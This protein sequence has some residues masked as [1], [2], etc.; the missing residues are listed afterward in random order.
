M[1]NVLVDFPS[2]I[3]K[4]GSE[5]V[6]QYKESLDERFFDLKTGVAG[7]MLQKFSNYSFRLAIVG[8]FSCYASKSL[9]DF[10]YECNN[11]SLVFFVGG[12]QAAVDRLIPDSRA[13]RK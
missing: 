5:V 10:M 9:R 12:I 3:P 11:G 8:D 2:A 7:E 13:D 6:E 1:D 4:I